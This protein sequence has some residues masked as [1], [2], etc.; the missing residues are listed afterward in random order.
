[1]ATPFLGSVLLPTANTPYQL[2]SM[3]NE[4]PGLL[5]GLTG[6]KAPTGRS[7]GAQFISIQSDP[8]NGSGILRIG[9]SPIA[10][11]FCGAVVF[12][13]QSWPIFSMDSNLIRLTDIWLMSDTDD[14]QVNIGYIT[15]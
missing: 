2:S 7:Q 14:T 9:N 13:G 1:M 3:P 15:R 12:S 4:P 11:G 6:S 10:S 5:Q 8:N